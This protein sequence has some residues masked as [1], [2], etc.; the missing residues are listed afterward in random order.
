MASTDSAKISDSLS[1]EI[2]MR[3][4][5]LLLKTMPLYRKRT[6]KAM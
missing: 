6:W 3:M 1:K 4:E 2:A 5:I